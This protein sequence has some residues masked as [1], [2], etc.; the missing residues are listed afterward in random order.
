MEVL[1]WFLVCSSYLNLFNCDQRV[2]I[3]FL[4]YGNYWCFDLYDPLWGMFHTFFRRRYILSRQ[5]VVFYTHTVLIHRF[6]ICEFVY[7]IKFICSPKVNS[8]VALCVH[9]QSWAFA[10]WWNIWVAQR[11]FPAG[12]EQAD[13]AV[14][15]HLSFCKHMSFSPYI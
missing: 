10:E 3:I 1:F 14:L 12:L 4:L 9:L 8:W 5:G 15:S 2:F 13:T 6:H 11:A 7:L